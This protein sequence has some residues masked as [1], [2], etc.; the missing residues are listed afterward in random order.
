MLP[1]NRAGTTKMRCNVLHIQ[2]KGLLVKSLG[3]LSSKGVNGKAVG[4]M[5]KGSLRIQ[6]GVELVVQAAGYRHQQVSIV[7]V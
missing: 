1:A 7:Q 4:S 6:Q 5:R 2:V 3:R